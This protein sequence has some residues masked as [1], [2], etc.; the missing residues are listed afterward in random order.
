MLASTSSSVFPIQ[1]IQAPAISL[2]APPYLHIHHKHG[3][4]LMVVLFMLLAVDAHWQRSSMETATEEGMVLCLEQAGHTS[5]HA[6]WGN[7]SCG[8]LSCPW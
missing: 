7:G 5:V 2:P 8:S 6:G 3:P 1:A 4:V